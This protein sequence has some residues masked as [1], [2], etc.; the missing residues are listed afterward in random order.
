MLHKIGEEGARRAKVW[1]DAT[2]RVKSSWSAYD[3]ERPTGLPIL[4]QREARA[5]LTIWAEIS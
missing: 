3:R 1:L 5:T 2:T 4:G